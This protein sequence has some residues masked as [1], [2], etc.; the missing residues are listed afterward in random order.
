M[1]QNFIDKPFNSFSFKGVTPFQTKF[2]TPIKKHNKSLH[3]QSLLLNDTNVTSDDDEHILTRIPKIL[4]PPTTRYTN[5]KNH[6][7][8]YLN[9]NSTQHQR[10]YQNLPLL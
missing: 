2:K 6:F 4:S 3:Q 10:Q 5:E 7:P 1:E 8:Q 9:Q